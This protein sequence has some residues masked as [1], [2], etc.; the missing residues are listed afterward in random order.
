MQ[1]KY[2]LGNQDVDTFVLTL[3]MT[4]RGIEDENTKKDVGLR[5]PHSFMEVIDGQ[6]INYYVVASEIE[7]F[8]PACAKML[9]NKKGLVEQF[10]QKTIESTRKIREYAIEYIKKVNDLSDEEI[11]KILEKS[12]SLQSQCM[13]DGTVVAFADI[14]GGITNGL[15][16]IIRKRT[17]LKH[18]LHVYTNILG[19][20]F[21]TGLAQEAYLVIQSTQDTN[22]QVLLDKYFWLDQGYIG[23][24]LTENQLEEI[25]KEKKQD[26]EVSL[27]VNELLRELN[28]SEEEDRVFFVSREIITTKSLRADSR[29]F[30]HVV[31]NKLTDI[32][33]QRW[34][35]EPKYVETMYAYEITKVLRG[36]SNVP[37]NLE[38][39]WSHSVFLRKQDKTCYEMLEGEKADKFIVSNV[40][41]EKTS[42]HKQVEGQTAQPGK[43]SGIARLVFGP[44]HNNK[45]KDG[46]IV[47]STATS[48]QLLPA[49]RKAAAF[50]TD[51]GGIT[52][53]AAIVARELKKPCVVGTQSATKIFKD[54]DLVEVD[55]DNGVVRILEKYHP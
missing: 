44:Q 38:N 12:T 48:P 52:S 54:G 47:I 46:D 25:R 21:E 22:N 18:P 23:R 35:I 14:Y 2:T 31:I 9:L 4:W 19:S 5:P 42:G 41:K 8:I 30:L 27:P 16:D 32:L 29:Q 1:E 34:D 24:G 15:L 33:A 36:L 51:V 50:V 11:I 45:V 53:H 10:K 28:L 39:R 37:S 7:Q 49:M 13:T 6:T 26:D 17:N 3:E 20:P 40:I 43:V 55:A